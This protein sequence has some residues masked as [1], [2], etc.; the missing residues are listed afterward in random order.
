MSILCNAL[1]GS[2]SVMWLFFHVEQVDTSNLQWF[3]GFVLHP[4]VTWQHC[5]QSLYSFLFVND[6]HPP[7]HA[8]LTFKTDS[9]LGKM[10][11][12]QLSWLTVDD[13]RFSSSQRTVEM[14]LTQLS[15]GNNCS[16]LLFQPYLLKRRG[17]VQ[18]FDEAIAAS[19]CL[20]L[21]CVPGCSSQSS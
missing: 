15:W 13:S 7:F 19:F 12:L 11:S 10:L 2:C 20:V 4:V 14:S 5:I 18:I 3:L 9:F 1:K 17:Q 8:T 16:F 6:L 21:I